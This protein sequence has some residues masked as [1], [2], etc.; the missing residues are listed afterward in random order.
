MKRPSN[1]AIAINVV[2]IGIMGTA[3][4]AAIRHSVFPERAEACV[5]RYHQEQTLAL[6]KNKQKIS[7][8]DLQASLNGLD[9]G[10]TENLT[11]RELKE[12]PANAA[13]GARYGANSRM[14]PTAA[15]PAG[16]F[17]FPWQPRGL[18][19][20]AQAACLSYHVFVPKDFDFGL[21]GVLP[22]LSA[23]DGGTVVGSLHGVDTAIIWRGDGSIESNVSRLTESDRSVEQFSGNRTKLEKGRWVR[24]DHEMVLNT[25][26]AA[27]GIVRTWVNKSLVVEAI[28]KTLREGSTVV[29][30][31][32]AAHTYFGGEGIGGAAP[33]EQ[34]LWMTPFEVRWNNK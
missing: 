6:I 28:E 32:V 24:I 9:I 17:S 8:D 13:I 18:P 11:I 4:Y 1:T 29:Q 14:M 25:P 3:A 2:A 33:K 20:D 21:G 34:T 5:E 16:G 10:V 23:R 12:G 30:T 7:P 27:N 15:S 19:R 31:G 26:K 22:G